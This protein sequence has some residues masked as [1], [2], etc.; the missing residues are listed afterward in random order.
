[1][2]SHTHTTI[3]ILTKRF[4]PPKIWTDEGLEV[5]VPQMDNR[6]MNSPLLSSRSFSLPVFK[7]SDCVWQSPLTVPVSLMCRS[8]QH[9]HSESSQ[10][11][12]YFNAL[13][14]KM[15]EGRFPS[16]PISH[17]C[18]SVFSPSVSSLHAKKPDP[19]LSWHYGATYRPAK[20]NP[21]EG[22]LWQNGVTACHCAN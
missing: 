2:L 15:N 3:C 17:F 8:F 21:C 20:I 6:N 14:Q 11:R 4:W 10:A 7:L 13:F 18:R 5:Q 16:P 22:S 19:V 9:T 12:C 1:M